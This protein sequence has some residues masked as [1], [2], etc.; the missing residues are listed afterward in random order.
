MGQEQKAGTGITN[1]KCLMKVIIS[2]YRLGV[3]DPST[4]NNQNSLIEQSQNT[5]QAISVSGAFMEGM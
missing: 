3:L 2:I 5:L 4:L 1:G